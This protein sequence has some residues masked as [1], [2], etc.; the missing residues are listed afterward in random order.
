MIDARMF[1]R[2][3]SRV[4]CVA[5]GA[6]DA[7]FRDVRSMRRATLERACGSA[8]KQSVFDVSS[9]F[10][11]ASLDLNKVGTRQTVRVWSD[12]FYRIPFWCVAVFQE[13]GFEKSMTQIQ[14]WVDLNH[15]RAMRASSEESVCRILSRNMKV[16][17]EMTKSKETL[18]VAQQLTVQAMQ[19]STAQV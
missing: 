7:E 18:S 16:L 9:R 10:M 1:S 5:K 4:V 11:K 15:A 3:S 2:I 6:G 12:S 19:S 17:H 14:L 8:L 13:A